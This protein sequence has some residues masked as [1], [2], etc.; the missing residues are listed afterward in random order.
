MTL[1]IY[2]VQASGIE[3]SAEFFPLT[4]RERT[5]AQMWAIGIENAEDFF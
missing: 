1:S 3:N 4:T 2:A 5:I